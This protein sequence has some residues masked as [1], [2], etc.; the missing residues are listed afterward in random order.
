[1]THDDQNAKGT[2]V[3]KKIKVFLVDD[4]NL[5][6]EGLSYRF[7]KEDDLEICGTALT[8]KDAVP[9]IVKSKPHVVV[10][11][12]SLP[13]GSGIELV[14]ILKQK[15]PDT[16][17]IV[18]TMQEELL[19]GSRSIRAGAKG[20]LMKTRPLE[21][22]IE[23]VRTVSKGEMYISDAIRETIMKL[24]TNPEALSSIDS[25]TDREFEIF[26]LIGQGYRPRHIKEK[27]NIS[28]GT[29]DAHCKTIRSKLQINTMTELIEY[30]V[31]ILK[32]SS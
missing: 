12:L 10:T 6:I 2:I 20:F 18:V 14:K 13:D 11:D 23:A 26:C 19:F 21:H 3:K 28:V 1:M 17:C 32:P 25:L 22:V 30:A 5:I 7:E 4:H 29:I 24:S 16:V 9:A 15:I 8:V 31:T 27:L